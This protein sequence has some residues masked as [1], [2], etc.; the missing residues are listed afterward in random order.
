LGV[1]QRI[2]KTT[3]LRAEYIYQKGVH[4]F[5]SRD[6][7]API[8]GIRP[9]NSFGNINQVQTSAFFVRNS[10]NI[11]VDGNLTKQISYTIDY[12]LSKIVS[13]N[14][15]IFSLPSD[16]YNLRNDISV[17]DL[18]QRHRLNLFLSWQI[19]KGLRLSAIYSVN[20]PLPYTITT[21]FDNNHDTTFND[22]PFGIMRNSVRGAWNNQLDVNLGYSFSFIKRKGGKSDKGF[23]V[24]TNS[25]ES[26]FDFTDPEKRFSLRFFANAENILNH[27]NLK[28]FS[29][30]Q[31]SPLFLKPTTAEQPRRITLGIRFNF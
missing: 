2:F 1:Q 21:G 3:S 11:G 16:N 20:S 8:N 14:D 17:S 28:N 4:Q 25:A 9:N 31:A 27:T 5:R 23:S 10:L 15:N 30:V 29:G 24:V 18:D 26:G 19:K 22:R 12:S 7:N 13:D 6:I